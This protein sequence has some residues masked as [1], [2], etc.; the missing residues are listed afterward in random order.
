MNGAQPRPNWVAENDS[1]RPERTFEDL[2]AA[3]E[4][5]VAAMNQLSEQA[6]RGCNFEVERR[7][8]MPQFCTVNRY[9]SEGP[10]R[11]SQGHVSFHC[12]EGT[13]TVQARGRDESEVS[14]ELDPETGLRILTIGDERLE[15]WQVSRKILSGLF[16]DP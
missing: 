9:A 10:R 2:I 13:I 8:D 1:C 6:R 14:A 4:A 11:I 16:F 15:L 5:D 12:L 7:K 3:V